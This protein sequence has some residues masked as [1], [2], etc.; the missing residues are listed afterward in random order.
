MQTELPIYHDAIDWPA[1]FREVPVPDVFAKT[2]WTWPRDQ[3]RE[4]QNKRFLKIVEVGWAH[5]FY[6]ALWGKAGLEPGDIRSL[7]DIVKLPMITTDDIK[8]SEIDAPP[9]GLIHN[10]GV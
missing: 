3:I 2:M 7:D 6:K 1:F 10:I 9:F 5:P 8:Q 4:L